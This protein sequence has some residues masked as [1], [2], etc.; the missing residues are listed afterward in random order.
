MSLPRPDAELKLTRHEAR[1]AIVICF[2][3][4]VLEGFDIQLLGV[5]APR[6]AQE[7]RIEP[8]AMTLIFLATNV[9]LLIGAIVGGWISDRWGRRRVLIASTML[10]GLFT[11][12]TASAVGLPSLL[13]V[14][15]VAGMGLGSALPS[16]VATAADV[17]PKDRRAAT[18]T[19]MFCGVPLGGASVAFLAQ[20]L[21]QNWGWRTLFHAGGA[22]PLLLTVVIWIALPE[23]RSVVAS[24]AS[25][26]SPAR[27]LFAEGRASKSVLLWLA[28]GP[29]LMAL[30]LLLYWLPTLL[31][32]RGADTKLAAQAAGIFN[33]AGIAGAL[34]I[35]AMLDRWGMRAV[36]GGSYAAFGITVVVLSVVRDSGSI[37]GLSAVAGFLILG[38]TYCVYAVAGSCYPEVGRATGSGATLSIG[39]LGSI[40]GPTIPGLLVIQGFG[41]GGS[42]RLLAPLAAVAG[43]AI[44]ALDFVNAKRGRLAK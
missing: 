23:T 1:T 12:G 40:L 35:G 18:T 7:L 25:L 16:M 42:L 9:G 26:P 8:V 21:S 27:V 34:T 39:R 5:A 28:A 14:R 15:F 43:L 3:I 11:L 38:L 33:L 19:M 10:F 41:I 4:G 32:S 2:A 36:L 20:Y 30:Y 29:T 31:T 22:A 24:T 17:S 6:M 44:V 37:V 13:V